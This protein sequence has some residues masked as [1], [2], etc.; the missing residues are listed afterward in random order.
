MLFP[1]YPSLPSYEYLTSGEVFDVRRSP[2][3]TGILTEF[4]R[5]HKNAIRS[6]HP[7]LSVCAIGPHARSLTSE[8]Q[9]SPFPYDTCSPYYKITQFGG[10]VIGLGV[11]TKN[12]AFVHCV[13]DVLRD[14]FPVNPYHK[15]LFDAECTDYEGET[16]I[17]KTYAHNRRK[18]IFSVPRYISK[19]VPSEV[20]TDLELYGMSFFR[21]DARKL[22]D[23]MASLTRNNITI[24][25]RIFY[26]GRRRSR[27]NLGHKTK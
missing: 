13:D 23:L 15:Q 8:H 7:T 20:C 27:E 21:A 25:P 5:R 6:L 10:K 4:A 3:Y 12:L 22:F 14:E 18:L 24:Y 26:R 19:N 9:N 11:S 2:S 16:Q 17:V 1:T